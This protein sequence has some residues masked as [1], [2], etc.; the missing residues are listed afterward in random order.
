M[1]RSV[2]SSPPGGDTKLGLFGRGRLGTAIADAAGV[3]LA[4]Q[5]TREEPPDAP[6]DVVVD[7][8]VPAA[9]AEHLEWALAR[10]VDLVI[11]VTGW[12][13][14]DLEA[15]VGERIGV[16]VAPNLSLGVALLR[17]MALV[18]ARWAALDS[19]RDPYIVE[20][21]HRAKADAPSGTARALA[22]AM[23]HELPVHTGWTI[24]VP[25][26]AGGEPRPAVPHELP[27]AVLRAGAEVGTHTVGVDSPAETVEIT[28][29]ARSREVFAR[30]A[31]EA[32]RFIHGRRGVFGLDDFARTV[33]DPLFRFGGEP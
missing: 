9:V 17:R 7:A 15:R 14:P 27:I 19:E 22:E 21:H 29:R 6:V 11:A 24:G 30:G 26:G 32:A 5:V 28:H 33:L 31:L 25:A 8:S 20:H 18:L 3:R 16:L 13:L 23:L 12:T 4:W 10:R 2:T 1:N